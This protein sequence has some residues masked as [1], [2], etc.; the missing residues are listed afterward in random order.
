MCARTRIT[1][2][3][4]DEDGTALVEFAIVLPMMI[5]LF[6]VIVEGSRLLIGYNSVIT[7]VRDAARYL[8]RVL[9]R[10]ICATGGSAAAWTSTV[11]T[12]VTRNVSGGSV[13]PSS[14]AVVSV[15]PGIACTPGS[16]RGGTVGVATVTAS[17]TVTYPFSGAFSLGGTAVPNEAATVTDRARII[18]S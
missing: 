16:Y 3:L 2:F 9:P 10:D 7:G 12:I 5:L 6:A 18:G 1:R 14:V 13:L 17:F 8:S 4:R 11:T 15:T